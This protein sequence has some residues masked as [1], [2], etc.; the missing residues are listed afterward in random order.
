[1][2]QLDSAVFSNSVII[3]EILHL[4]WNY[5]SPEKQLKLYQFILSTHPWLLIAVC[6]WVLQ[7]NLRQ[8]HFAIKN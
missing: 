5:V 4:I 3:A 8:M 7:Q 1:M 2:L 6:H